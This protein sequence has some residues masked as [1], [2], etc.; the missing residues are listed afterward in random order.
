MS[1]FFLITM[2]AVAELERNMM[3]ERTQTGKELARLQKDYKEGRPKK[4]IQ[5]KIC[6]M[7]YFFFLYVLIL[8]LFLLQE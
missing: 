7:R 1:R 8:E 3:V 2:L 6:L 4:N 5:M